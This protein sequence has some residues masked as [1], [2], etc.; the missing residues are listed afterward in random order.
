VENVVAEPTMGNAVKLAARA[1]R[2]ALS[3]V[4]AFVISFLAMAFT[5]N[6]NATIMGYVPRS[7]PSTY[8]EPRLAAQAEPLSAQ[9]FDWAVRVLTLNLGTIRAREGA[10]AV[11]AVIADSLLVTLLYLIP[12]MIVAVVAGTM[13]QLLAV[14]IERGDLTK[15]TTLLGAAAVATPV[16]LFIYVIQIYLPLVAY[17]LTGSF[18]E[19]GYSVTDSPLSLRNLRA[20]LWPFFAMTFY[21]FAIQLRASG[22]DLEQYAG[23]PFVKTARAK[24]VGLLGICRHVFPHSAARLLTLLS[25]EML[26]MVLVGLYVVEWVTETPGFGTLTIDA[27]GSRYPGLIFGVVLLPVGLVVA[28]NFFQDA[29]YTL[30]DPRVEAES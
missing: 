4:I 2:G 29:Y 5:K 28:V 13:V 6:P 27:V 1:G 22:T 9:F 15:K 21:L 8:G 18:I 30:V 26:G 25:S 23:E 10:V 11:G 17:R 14:A 19:L 20:A 7:L 24:G 12:A 3:M 16:F